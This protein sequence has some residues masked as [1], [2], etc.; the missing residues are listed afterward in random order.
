[1]PSSFVLSKNSV[2]QVQNL[3]V[4]PT[5][6]KMLMIFAKSFIWQSATVDITR[7]VG[8]SLICFLWDIDKNEFRHV[9]LTYPQIVSFTLTLS[10]L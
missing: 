10:F 3:S 1:M 8:Y 9:V 2:L 5:F 7:P 4:L 6:F